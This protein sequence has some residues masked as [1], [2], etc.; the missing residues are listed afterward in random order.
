[1]AQRPARSLAPTRQ[2]RGAGLKLHRAETVKT[3]RA[4]AASPPPTASDRR[5]N[6]CSPLRTEGRRTVEISGPPT[7]VLSRPLCAYRHGAQLHKSRLSGRTRL[8]RWLS[9]GGLWMALSILGLALAF[10]GVPAP[11]TIAG[12]IVAIVWTVSSQRL[13]RV[14]YGSVRRAV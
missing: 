7:A 8:L 10:A 2:L 1:M 11:R 6:C 14:I 9:F 5:A 12:A 4:D 3:A 13:R